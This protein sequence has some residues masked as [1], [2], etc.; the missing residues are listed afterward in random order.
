MANADALT[1]G[2]RKMG[3]LEDK[4]QPVVSVSSRNFVVGQATS[5]Y[6]SMVEFF[7]DRCT[8]VFHHPFEK[9][10]INMVMYYNH[11]EQVKVSTA[12]RELRFRIGHRLG[13]FMRDYKPDNP[14]HKLTIGFN[15][16]VDTSL[17]ATRVL[18]IIKR[19]AK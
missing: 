18:P 17:V 3:G 15:S 14:N 11:M 6:P 13:E 9:K 2:I 10:Q 16:S 4:E 7:A 12:R 8:Y 5:K 1:K 19:V